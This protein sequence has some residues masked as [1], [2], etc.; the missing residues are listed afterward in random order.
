MPAKIVARSGFDWVMIDMEHAPYTVEQMSNLVHAIVG[1]SAG[2]CL[3]IIR[4]PSHDPEWIKWALDSGT[5]GII[6]P[7]IQTAQEMKEVVQAARYPPVG[8]RSFGPAYAAYGDIDPTADRMAYFR[9]ALDGE[10]AILPIIESA[11][12]LQ[13]VEEILKVPG[14]TGAFLGPQDLRL[15]LGL[16]PGQGNEPAFVAALDRVMNAGKAVGKPIG[17]MGIGMDEVRAR[18]AAGMKFLLC[19]LD[20]MAFQ[21]GLSK[22]LKA[23]RA[24]L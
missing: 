14:V 1:A 8:N 17:S 4:I 22:D 16:S 3:P 2:Q 6:I 24:A 10:V 18:T 23:A 12:G 11:Q 19:S 5:A 15:S 9:R 7:M 13:N 20:G 21:A